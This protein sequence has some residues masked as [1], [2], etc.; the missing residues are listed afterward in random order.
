MKKT[1]ILSVLAL[2][3]FFAKAQT[4]K[5]TWFV[6]G[7]LAFSS[8]T[9]KEA[10]APGS[11][12]KAT[13]FALSPSVG[14]FFI[15]NLAA[16]ASLNITSAYSANSN[17]GSTSS[18]TVTLFS[19]GPFVRYYFN[20]SQH[21]KLFLHGDA[22]WGSE[23]VTLNYSGADESSSVPITTFEGKAG[24]AFFLSPGVA[25]E[26]TAG[27]QSTTEKDSGIKLTTGSVVVG[28]GFQIYLGSANMLRSKNK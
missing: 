20:T 16:G 7:A 24:A 25:L 14:Y 1:T 18:S 3:T 11:S 9:Q 12:A 4:E 21:V 26:F 2:S 10:D 27:Y 17:S 6:G 15:N 23:K 5:T 19:A 13:A 28:L 22:S 8:S